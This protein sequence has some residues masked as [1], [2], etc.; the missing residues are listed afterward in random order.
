[1]V[2]CVAFVEDQFRV[3]VSPLLMLVGLAS[4]VTVGVAGG[5]TYGVVSGL[6]A[7]GFLEQPKVKIAAASVRQKRA[8]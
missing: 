8:R 3:A 6:V 7:I 1:M 2:S 5:A 4:S